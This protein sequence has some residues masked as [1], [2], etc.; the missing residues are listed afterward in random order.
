MHGVMGGTTQSI[1]G[2]TAG[3]YTVTITD[4]NGCTDTEDETL[5]APKRHHPNNRHE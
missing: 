2:L 5:T 4:A 1:T 3:T